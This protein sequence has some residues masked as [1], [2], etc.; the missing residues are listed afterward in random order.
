MALC[1]GKAPA[2]Q[3]NL[4]LW[5]RYAGFRLLMEHVEHVHRF[6]ELRGIDGSV[7]VGPIT[8]DDLHDSRAAKPFNGL[9]AGSVSPCCAA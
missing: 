6:L 3:I 1:L 8:L 2:Y 5:R 9:A 7:R 4:V